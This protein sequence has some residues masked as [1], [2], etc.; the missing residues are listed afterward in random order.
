[1][2]ILVVWYKNFEY[3]D[4]LANALKANDIQADKFVI[5]YFNDYANV[6]KRIV[7]KRL[8]NHFKNNHSK[9]MRDA[10]ITK[11][12]KEGFDCI[13]ILNGNYT[14]VLDDVFFNWANKTNKNLILWFVDSA[15]T[16]DCFNQEYFKNYKS[17]YSYDPLD[18]DYLKGKY[19]I[20]NVH[21]LP[22]TAAEELYNDVEKYEKIYDICFVGVGSDNRSFLLEQVARY[23][24]KN[25]KTMVVYGQ[26]WR[27]R[28]FYH[29]LRYKYKFKKNYPYLY[30]FI[31]NKFIQPR[32]VAE[33]Y[34]QSRICLNINQLKQGAA[35]S[36]AFEILATQ[37]FQII[38][39]N[40]H[41][42]ALFE[43]KKDLVM[44]K[45]SDELIQL[46][47]YYLKNDG[48]REQIAQ[49]GYEK[50]QKNFLLKETVKVLNKN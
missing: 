15:R 13:L 37:G 9:N 40:E 29:K 14:D 3:L 38:D 34:K 20:D 49:N 16:I 39:Y 12:E 6:L 31:V 50:V 28:P 18:I 7:C 1:M 45:D 35:N 48:E 22:F 42:A 47:D 17:I 33:V 8:T 30:K 4:R 21:Y 10:L 36:R 19:S 11:C 25:N 2:K 27:F 43:D 44:Y 26:F 23:C 5:E 46:I 41:L 24:I 32:K